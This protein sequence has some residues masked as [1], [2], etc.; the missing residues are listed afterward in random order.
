MPKR[1]NDGL[2]KRCGC[3]RRQWPK[4]AHPWHF[5]FHHAGVEHRYSLDTIA[6]G[7]GA[8]PP[9]SKSESSTWRD[10]LRNETRAGSFVDPTVA[11][12]LPAADIRLTFGDEKGGA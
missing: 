7:R 11:P 12:P 1:T 8:Q 4:C 6:R 10:R 9:T 3:P 2:K 5:S